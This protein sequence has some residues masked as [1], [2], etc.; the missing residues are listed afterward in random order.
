MTSMHA[1]TIRRVLNIALT[2][3]LLWMVLTASIMVGI[4]IVDPDS[5]DPGESQMFLLVFGSMGFLS[6]VAFGT[7]LSLGERGRRPFEVPLPRAIL[8]GILGCAIV[9]T[10]YLNHGDAGLAANIQMALMFCAFG[11]L[12]TAV[13]LLIAR[14]WAHR[15]VPMH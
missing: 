2:W 3:C 9:Q 10:G 13:W 12:V 14:Q 1:T 11:G 7:F 4:G 6:G 8:W 5:I 15:R